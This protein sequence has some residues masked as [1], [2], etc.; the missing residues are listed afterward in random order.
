MSQVDQKSSSSLKSNSECLYHCMFMWSILVLKTDTFFSLKDFYYI[1]LF[2][3]G[4][5]TVFLL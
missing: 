5:K 4:T 1:L 3:Y 2:R